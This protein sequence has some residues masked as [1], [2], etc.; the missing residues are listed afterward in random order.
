M[1]RDLNQREPI[2]FERRVDEFDR[3]YDFL[4]IFLWFYDE[5]SLG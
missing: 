2:G 5:I 1:K 4:M 3:K